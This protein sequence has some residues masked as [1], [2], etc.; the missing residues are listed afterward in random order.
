MWTVSH[1]SS[2]ILL[3]LVCLLTDV[4]NG[5]NYDDDKFILNLLTLGHMRVE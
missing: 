3:P 1:G 2:E 4:S 5:G